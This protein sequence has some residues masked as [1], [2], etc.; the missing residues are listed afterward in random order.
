MP[1]II[2]IEGDLVRVYNQEMMREAR[3][4]DL[5]PHIESRP[6]ITIGPLPTS[7]RFVHWDESDARRKRVQMICEQMPG[8][9][10]TRYGNRRYVISVPWT[11]WVLD[12]TTAGNPLDTNAAWQMTNSRIY[13]ARER[14]TSLQS[15]VRRALIP[16]CDTLGGICYGNTG[17]PANLP[18]DVRVD[19]LISEFWQTEFT[20]DSGTGSPWQSETNTSSWARW[21]RESRANPNAWTL[22]PEWDETVGTDG[23]GKM[24]SMTMMSQLGR[25]ERAVAVNVEGAIRD[26]PRPMTFMRAEEWAQQYTPV[27][28]HRLFV[29]LQNLHADD[30]AAM[31][32]P[33]AEAAVVDDDLG[34][35]PI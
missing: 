8:N 34:G 31:T 16:N 23:R 9:K 18:L 27:E 19:R 28:R 5:L 12:F 17:V 32:P 11:Y 33:P 15:E 1:E 24:P 25:H 14:I 20:H 29:A 35:E 3:L 4:Q 7:A 26:L 21:D 22:F 30:P 10:T 2:Q 13:W 6:P